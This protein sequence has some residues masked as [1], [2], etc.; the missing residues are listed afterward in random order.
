MT[1]KI[2]RFCKIGIKV[3]RDDPSICI[4][5]KSMIQDI[6]T[7]DPQFKLEF[8]NSILQD[9]MVLER[10]AKEILSIPVRQLNIGSDL[11]LG[12]FLSKKR[13]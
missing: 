11:D 1:E 7:K 3:E 4:D 8:I 5:C 13:N 9:K 10:I 2:C 12:G 6:V